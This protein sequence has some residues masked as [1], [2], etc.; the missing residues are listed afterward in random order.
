MGPWQVRRYNDFKKQETIPEGTRVYLQPKRR[1]AAEAKQHIAIEGE[2]LRD[3]SQK[4]GVKMRR[5]RK[6][7]GFER[8]YEV[9]A[10]NKV[11]LR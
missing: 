4:Y 3:I 7:S 2:T 11:I 6:N 8:G 1:K 10:G 5:L 9:K